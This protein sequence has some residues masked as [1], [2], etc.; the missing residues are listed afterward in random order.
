MTVTIEIDMDKKC[1]ECKK[2]GAVA[3]GICLGCTAKAFRN[4]PMKSAIGRAVQARIR[5][6]AVKFWGTK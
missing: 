2:G 3:S 1:A 6:Q 4:K 5:E